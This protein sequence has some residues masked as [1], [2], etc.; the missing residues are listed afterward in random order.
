M[1][2]LAF[3]FPLL[4]LAGVAA[5]ILVA[6]AIAQDLRQERKY[7]YRQAFFTIVTLVMLVLSVG[8]L[9]S[10]LSV[11]LKTSAFPDANTTSYRGY[12]PQFYLAATPVVCTDTCTF[13]ES[14][15]ESFA[16]WKTD[17]QNWKS[18]TTKNTQ[19]RS[20]LASTIALLIVALPLFFIFASLME[21]GSKQEITDHQ[22]PSPLRSVYYYGV[23]LSGLLMAVVAA[24]SL[25]NTGLNIALKTEQATTYIS[26]EPIFDKSSLD[27]VVSCQ[28]ACG[29]TADDQ[30]LVE[31]WKTE[32]AN[33]QKSP[34]SGNSDSTFATMIP[35][36]A[37]GTPLFWFHFARIRRETQGHP[38][39]PPTTV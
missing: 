29:F 11:G 28:S 5:V 34:V 4:G 22:R 39:P 2:S 14:Q 12:P 10:L 26:P 32:S 23:A 15:K 20:E 3:V 9:S 38:T 6:I 1:N 16:T 33:A 35:I 18:Q 30:K 21:K 7:G 36:F 24:V 17:F 37:L 31:E 19:I 8:S 13:S 25:L 27:A